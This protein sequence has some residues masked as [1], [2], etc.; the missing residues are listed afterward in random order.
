MKN[1][2]RLRAKKYS[3]KIDN[4][5]QVSTFLFHEIKLAKIQTDSY[6]AFRLRRSSSQTK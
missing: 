4:M 3:P 6:L 5:I 2:F 1:D